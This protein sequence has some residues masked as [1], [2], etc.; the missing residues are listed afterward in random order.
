M[1]KAEQGASTRLG[2]IK[3]HVPWRGGSGV[4]ELAAK[5]VTLGSMLRSQGPSTHHTSA[6]FFSVI[7]A[8]CGV[9]VHLYIHVKETVSELLG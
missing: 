3:C 5:P 6:F 9:I 8:M 4:K 7:V 2:I 1:Q